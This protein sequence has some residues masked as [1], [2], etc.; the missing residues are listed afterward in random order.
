MLISLHKQATT[1]PKIRAAIQA[2]TEPTWLVAERYG[3]SEQTVWKWRGRDDVHDRSH[4]PHRLQTT[5]TPAQEAVAVALRKALLLPLD[6]MIAVVRGFL[7]PTR[8]TKRSNMK[9]HALALLV[10]LQSTVASADTSETWDFRPGQDQFSDAAL[11]DLSVLNED[12][13]GEAGFIRRSED[14][15]GFVL[16]DGEPIRFWAVNT[17]V[18]NQGMAE[19]R[20]HARFLAKRG[21][22]MVRFH[23]QIPQA[24]QDAGPLEAIDESERDRL[25]QLVAAMRDEGIYVTF[26]LYYPHAIREE[27]AQRWQ[28][29]EDSAGLTGMIYFDPVLQEAYKGWLR[30]TLLSLNP[31]TGLALRDDPAL[32]IIQMQNEDSL[33]FWTFNSIQGREARL[34]GALFGRFLEEKYGSLAAAREAWDDAT[35]LSPIG[36]MVDDWN[37]GVIALSGIWHL[38]ADAE[39]GRAATRL[40]DQAE[41]LTQT[42]Y[43]WHSE[44]ARFLREEIGAPQL[45]NAGNWRTA[46]NLVLD[47][48]ERY[49]YTAGDVIGV[50]RYVGALHEGE[51]RGWAIVAGDIFHE[52]G[53]LTRP[54]D[55]PVTLRQPR[56][57]PYIISETLWVPPMWQQ[58]EGPILMAAYQALTGIDISYWFAAR[59][60]QWRY[61]QSANGFLPSIGKWFVSTPQQMGAF[62]AAA[63]IFRLG[64]IDEAPPVVIEHRSLDA[65]WDRSPPIVAPQQGYDPNRDAGG[66]L[67]SLLGRAH[68][69]LPGASPYSFLA[70]PVHISFDSD[71]SNYIH[72]DLD[73]FIDRE[74]R[75]VRSATGQLEW[76]WGAGVVVLDAPRAQGVVGALSSRAYY[77]LQDVTIESEAAYASVIVVP[78]DNFPILDS[79]RLLVQINSIARPTGW[80]T[81]PVSHESG[82]A[83]EVTDFGRAP[84][85]IDRV[86]AS[87]EIRNQAGLS[88]ATALDPNGMATGPVSIVRRGEILTLNLPSNALYVIVE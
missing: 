4:T 40:S 86:N 56:G 48:L 30:E 68:T 45:F 15:A 73:T 46:D 19:L 12:T 62:P 83:L 81:R 36:D 57:Y 39:P 53:L 88:Q 11:L 87:L 41:F 33:L 84:W 18:A 58:S 47:D 42:M 32:A 6:D 29:P 59:E 9:Q 64:L 70:G 10:L 22:N 67:A 5:L 14:G 66:F 77:D 49:S 31:H 60:T 3:I 43:D 74:A 54:L 80:R 7:A 23:G 17:Y 34:L 85:Q 2:S 16:G 72:P 13:A 65:L 26:S 21:V 35:A 82:Q 44:I 51:H 28:V 75:V 1:T 27:V 52:E 20:E 63:L 8:R 50:N 24:G 76:D 25:W 78:L 71:A 38:T 61:P 37:G 55:L 69:D 79:S